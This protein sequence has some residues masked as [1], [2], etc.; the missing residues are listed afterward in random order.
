MGAQLGS[1]GGPMADIN[2]T[3][4]I[5]VVLVLLVVFM[6]VTPMLQSGLPVDLP[7]ASQTKTAKMDEHIV[8][9]VG[10]SDECKEFPC[11]LPTQWQVE[12]EDATVDTLSSLINAEWQKDATYREALCKKDPEIACKRALLIKGDRRLRYSQVREVMDLLASQRFTSV[13]VAVEREE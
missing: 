12:Q 1:G 11:D 13:A 4:L 6:V 8:I 2:V 3:P 7:V 5:D 10:P 9:S